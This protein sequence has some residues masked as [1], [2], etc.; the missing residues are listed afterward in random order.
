VGLGGF[1]FNLVM[2][3]ARVDQKFAVHIPFLIIEDASAG[4]TN[5]NE[6]LCGTVVIGAEKCLK[7]I[8]KSN[9]YI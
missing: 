7:N 9:T 2:F 8:S 5:K 6:L 4:K 1:Q 3:F